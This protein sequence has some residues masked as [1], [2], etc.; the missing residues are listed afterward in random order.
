MARNKFYKCGNTY[1]ENNRF[2]EIT[3]SQS[4][5]LQLKSIFP[6]WSTVSP[7]MTD[8]RYRYGNSFMLQENDKIVIDDKFVADIFIDYF[9]NIAFHI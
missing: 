4:R 6:F 7:F 1:W 3:L 5:L 9:C 2:I 8:K